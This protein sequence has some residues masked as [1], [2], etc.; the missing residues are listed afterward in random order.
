[1]DDQGASVSNC[2]IEH[3]SFHGWDAVRLSNGLVSLVAVP[4]VGGRIMAYDLGDYPYLW[5]DRNLAGKLFSPEENMG[6]GSIVAWKNYGGDKTWPAP[7]GWDSPDQWHGPPDP[8]LDTGR[9]ALEILDSPAAAASIR[10][11]S[12]PDPRT[13]V[14]ISRQVTLHAGG[15]R[16]SLHLE[17]TNVSD[18]VRSWGIWDIVQ[19][20][21]TSLDDNGEETHNEQAWLY[22]PTS[23]DSRFSRG[24]NVMFGEEDNP[25]WQPEVRPNLLGAQYLYQLGKIGIDSTAGWIAFV[26]Q[27]TDFAF[28]QCFTYFPGEEYPDDGASVECWTT[29]HGEPV[30]GLDFGKLNLFHMEAEILGPLRSMAPGETQRLDIDWYVARCPGPIVNV[31]DA[32]CANQRLRAESIDAGIRLT[33]VF[34][35]FHLGSVQLVWLDEDECALETE[36]LALVNPLNVLRVDCVRRPPPGAQV[37]Q[38]LL[39]DAQGQPISQL[40]S[41]PI[42]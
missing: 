18:Q 2:R 27:A 28:C 3:I 13:G 15:G 33:G 19:V 1:M 12:L 41:C 14:Q 16:V 9:Y 42:R 23:S 36:T 21:A 4:D 11:E 38:L 30:G 6:D 31:T 29:G 17:M 26:N 10:M 39:C 40:D 25:E 8:V 37:A 24:F 35:L 32:G 34:G 7:Q 22:I 5:F 20:D